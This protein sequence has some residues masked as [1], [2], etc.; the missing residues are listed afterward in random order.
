MNLLKKLYKESHKHNISDIVIDFEED[1]DNFI[2]TCDNFIH[3]V[4]YVDRTDYYTSDTVNLND[5]EEDLNVGIR[6]EDE[7]IESIVNS[8]YNPSKVRIPQEDKI[9]PQVKDT[10]IITEMEDMEDMEASKVDDD[11]TKG[12]EMD[13]TEVGGDLSNKLSKEGDEVIGDISEI[14]DD[15]YKANSE[16]Y[17]RIVLDTPI[18]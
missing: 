10:L 14:D 15:K 16:D 1:C 4:L 13:E 12:K 7:V 8:N 5:I 2:Q 18:S 17:K 3:N 11:L 6:S 9:N